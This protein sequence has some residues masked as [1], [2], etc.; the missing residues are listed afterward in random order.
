[1]LA[2]FSTAAFW[3]ALGNIIV[4]NVVLSGDNAIV[5]ALAARSLA[6]AQQRQAIV[7]GSGAAIVLRIVLTIFA[8]SLLTLP[9]LKIAGALLLLYIGMSLSSEETGPQEVGQHASLAAAIRTILLADLVMSLDNVLGVAAAAKGNML[10]LVIGLVISI[11]LIVFGSG[12]LLKLV[13]RLPVIVWFGAA[14]LGY[15]AG[16][17]LFADTALQAWIAATVPSHAW[18]VPGTRMLL[19][20]PGIAGAA[21]A[22]AGGRWLARR[23]ATAAPAQKT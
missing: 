23:G 15:L 7:L 1:M 21:L 8:V 14:L 12:I 2:Q 19:S 20:L 22:L 6:P 16:E 5:I 4:V 17:M 11:P 10:L 3:L 9:Y 18:Q 13:Q